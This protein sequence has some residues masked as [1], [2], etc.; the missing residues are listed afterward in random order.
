MRRKSYTKISIISRDKE[1]CQ[2]CGYEGDL[3]VHHIV[4]V[5]D[6]GNNSPE[7]LIT[8]CKYCH[9][10]L[11]HT[12]N[13]NYNLKESLKERAKFIEQSVFRAVKIAMEELNEKN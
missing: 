12:L 11:H 13:H 8:L 1:K 5:K 6:C 3:R 9:Y 4:P 10:K 7:N 2:I